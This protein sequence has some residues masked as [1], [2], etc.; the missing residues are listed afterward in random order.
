MTSQ[1]ILPPQILPPPK[2][3]S[4]GMALL[5]VVEPPKAAVATLLLV[6]I[7]TNPTKD[8]YIPQTTHALHAKF[9]T[10]LDTP[11]FNAIT[12][13]TMPFNINP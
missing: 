13:F 3:T 6:A 5:V 4:V 12:D 11:P 10:N 1:P 7:Q 2:R 9:V 8:P